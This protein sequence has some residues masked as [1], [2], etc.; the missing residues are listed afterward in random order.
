MSYL[1]NLSRTPLQQAVLGDLAILGNLWLSSAS[2]DDLVQLKFSE[3][4]AKLF[5][6]NELYNDALVAAIETTHKTS[7]EIKTILSDSATRD[8]FCRI[9]EVKNREFGNVLKAVALQCPVDV[10]CQIEPTWSDNR[11]NVSRIRKMYKHEIAKICR[12]M[13]LKKQELYESFT[14]DEEQIAQFAEKE[15]KGRVRKPSVSEVILIDKAMAEAEELNLTGLLRYNF[16]SEKSCTFIN[17]ICLREKEL[18][19]FEE[20]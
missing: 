12:M 14:I 6:N 8:R 10:L 20:Y 2:Y 13:L 3:N 17:Q 9:L 11:R 16:I 19:E 4:V 1:Q 7:S 18:K 15:V 5:G